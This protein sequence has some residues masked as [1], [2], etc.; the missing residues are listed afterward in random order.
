MP[1]WRFPKFEYCG[2]WDKNQI[3]DI[4]SY[5][6]PDLYIVKNNNYKN[7]GVPILTANKSFILGYTDEI[8]GIYDSV[9]VVL[10]DDFT[11]DK[12]YVDFPFKVKSSAIKI[13][14]SKGNNVLKFIFELMNTIKFDAQEHKRYY[15]SIYQKLFVYIPKKYL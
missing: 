2:N 12:K 8:E 15:I 5:E 3:C 10:F 11:T 7:K 4:L 13:L 14:R 1:E 6:R 9:P